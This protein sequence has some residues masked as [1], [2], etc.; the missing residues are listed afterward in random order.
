MNDFISEKFEIVIDRPI[1]LYQIDFAI[2][3]FE[4]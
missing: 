2:E 3:F 4:N 1:C